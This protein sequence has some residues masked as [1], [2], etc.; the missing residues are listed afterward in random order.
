[1]SQRNELIIKAGTKVTCSDGH[2]V[3]DV[4]DNIYRYEFL[5]SHA[6]GNWQIDIPIPGQRIVDCKCH[7]GAQYIRHDV[8]NMYRLQIHTAEGWIPE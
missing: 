3:C 1:M 7:C 5:R 2:H 6:F 8:G 4:V